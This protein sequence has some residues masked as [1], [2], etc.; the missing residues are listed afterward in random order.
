MTESELALLT[1]FFL[2]L[3]VFSRVAGMLLYLPVIGGR[4]IPLTA[5]LFTALALALVTMSSALPAGISLPE[6]LPA[7]TLLMARE[8]VIGLFLSVALLV[9]FSALQMTGDFI[10]RLG[11]VSISALFDPATGENVP[12]LSRFL[13][14]LGITVFLLSGG[15]EGFLTGFMD[16]FQKVPPGDLFFSA[17]GAVDTLVGLASAAMSLVV[18]MSAP[19]IITSL[20]LYLTIGLMGRAVPQLNIL[21]IGLSC[22]TILVI[23]ILFLTLGTCIR[24]FQQETNSV[25]EQIFSLAKI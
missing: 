13:Y 10:G 11:G 12:V 19:I 16:S 20:S 17:T 2:F 22:N 1:R 9:F 21:S 14:M 3:L 18:R 15:L 4:G 25:L 6:N 5:R 8:L 24:F 7:A 23:A